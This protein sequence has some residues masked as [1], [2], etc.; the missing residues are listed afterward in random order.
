MNNEI[1]WNIGEELGSEVVSKVACPLKVCMA[2]IL[3]PGNLVASRPIALALTSKQRDYHG[4][5]VR[6]VFGQ[7]STSCSMNP[8]AGSKILRN[9]YAGKA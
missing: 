2:L 4:P 1:A 6:W 7:E 5:R 3:I 8:N 9:V